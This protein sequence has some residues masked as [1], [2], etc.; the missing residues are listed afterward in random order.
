LMEE[1]GS[2]CPARHG[3]G[4]VVLPPGSSSLEQ[5]STARSAKLSCHPEPQADLSRS[6]WSPAQGVIGEPCGETGDSQAFSGP[7]RNL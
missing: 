6:P 1:Q 7:S 4:E 2:R 3:A 5:R